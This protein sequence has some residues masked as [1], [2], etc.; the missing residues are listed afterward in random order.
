MRFNTGGEVSK[1]IVKWLMS[2]GSHDEERA[3]MRGFCARCQC[4]SARGCNWDRELIWNE[5]G[6]LWN[7]AGCGKPDALR[8]RLRRRQSRSRPLTTIST[9]CSPHHEARL[10]L[11]ARGTAGYASCGMAG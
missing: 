6:V 1:V 10:T 7:G 2:A 5:A 11:R 8:T 3:V 4:T 9:P